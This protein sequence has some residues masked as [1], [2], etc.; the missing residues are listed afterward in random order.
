MMQGSIL[1][2]EDKGTNLIFRC[3]T[4]ADNVGMILSPEDGR[5]DFCNYC[6][7]FMYGMKGCRK[8]S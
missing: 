1:G 2:T 4:G 6:C 5:N 8:Q 3:A 7:V